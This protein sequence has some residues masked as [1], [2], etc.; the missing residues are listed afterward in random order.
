MI[1]VP[2]FSETLAKARRERRAITAIVM[3][4]DDSIRAVAFGPRGGW[5]FL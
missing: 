4:A 3:M 5:R 2:T 1:A